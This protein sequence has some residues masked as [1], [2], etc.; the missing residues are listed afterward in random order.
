MSCDAC[1]PKSKTNALQL[2]ER[3]KQVCPKLSF[4]KPNSKNQKLLIFKR[5]YKSKNSIQ[6]C[7]LFKL[8]KLTL[9]RIFKKG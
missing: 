8:V 6:N 4:S 2:L 1:L 7:N 9:K 5:I 3:Q